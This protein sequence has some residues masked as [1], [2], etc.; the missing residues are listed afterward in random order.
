M[1]VMKKK[2]KRMKKSDVLRRMMRPIIPGKAKGF[3]SKTTTARI[4]I[5]NNKVKMK[6][7]N[8]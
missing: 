8:Y 7:K 6:R 5:D 3:L 4:I 1:W 2:E